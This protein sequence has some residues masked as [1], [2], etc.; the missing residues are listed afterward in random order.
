MSKKTAEPKLVVP[1]WRPCDYI[2]KRGVQYWWAP[3][4]IRNLNGSPAKIRP[5]KDKKSG[6]VDLHME[7]KDGKKLSYI[8]GSIQREFK[9][10]HE[11]RKIDYLLL[12][13]DEDQLLEVDRSEATEEVKGQVQQSD[14]CQPG[15]L[16]SNR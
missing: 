13:E 9:K 12:G 5:I 11:D 15:Q 8:Q 6:D 16:Y 7:S 2:S 1:N 10:W 14:D 3:E 4:W